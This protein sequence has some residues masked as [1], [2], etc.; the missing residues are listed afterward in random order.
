MKP[1]PGA[2]PETSS[3]PSL[4][5][6]AVRAG[7]VRLSVRERD[8]G[9]PPVLC[10]HGLASNARWWD[11]VGAR[12]APRHRVLA[13][14][15]RGHGRSDKPDHGYDLPT[16][17]A[18]LRALLAALGLPPVV[19]VG[20]SWGASV[21]LGLAAD[22]PAAVLGVVCVDGGFGDLRAVFG[23][24]WA[25]AEAAM[26]PPDFPGAGR[27]ELP[28]LLRGSALAEGSDAATA[29]EILA[30][31]LEEGADGRLRARL[32][33]PRHMAI[34]RALYELDGPAL[35]RRVSQPVLLLPAGS[36]AG[37]AARGREA[38]L[39][40]ALDA[41]GGRAAVEWVDGGHDL[42][43]QRPAAVAEA[44]RRFTA[45]WLG[46]PADREGSGAR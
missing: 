18:D 7:T 2:A 39:R 42:P 10:L 8:G 34:A 31:N 20:H 45:R 6:H 26:T 15:Q 23:G 4:R 22:D 16:A 17:V 30:G 21:A 14:D 5:E 24:S 33:R 40:T 19:A 37:A 25:Q 3:A 27:A 43:V 44:V 41:L 12:L 32:T 36:P 9:A 35:L 38:G 28:R 11:L 1:V 29:A 46:G 13:V